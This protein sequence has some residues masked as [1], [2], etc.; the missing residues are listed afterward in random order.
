MRPQDQL[1]GLYLPGDSVVHRMGVGAKYA[2]LFAAT[3]PALLFDRWPVALGVLGCS[4]LVLLATGLP[5]RLT[6]R[7]PGGLV[8]LFVLVLGYHA[9]VGTPLVGVGVAATLLGCV[10]L[11][12]ALTMTT[13][14][15]ILVDALVGAT[16]PLARFGFPAERFGLAVA[17]MLRSIPFLVGLF[18]DV[19]TAARAR[20]LERNW[21]ALLT[22]AVIG[23]VAYAQR[24][25]DALV[26]RGLGDD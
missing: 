10:Y 22:P 24:T 5:A 1:F 12:R 18:G 21:F 25:G 19:R 23:A 7:L 11:S 8:L 20:G 15:P 14:A 26:A 13:P 2:L 16:R 3:L 17:L 4:V 6:L 9:V